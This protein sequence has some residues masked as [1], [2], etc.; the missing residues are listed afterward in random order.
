MQQDT[1]PP[2][3]KH[4]IHLPGRR[5]HR[6]QIDKRNPKRLSCIGLP[7]AWLQKPRQPYT[8]TAAR[9]AAFSP[10]VLFDDHPNIQPCHWPHIGE[11]LPTDSQDFN[12]LIR[13][14]HRGRH[15][16]HPRIERA[17][18]GV[19]LFQNIEFGRETRTLDRV[20]RLIQPRVCAFRPDRHSAAS[21]T[22][23][24]TRC[25]NCASHC[26]FANFRRMRVASDLTKHGAHP[27]TLRCIKTSSLDTP[28]IQNKRFRLGTL[29]KKLSILCPSASFFQQIKGLSL[30][31][32]C[33]KRA[34]RRVCHDFSCLARGVFS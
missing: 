23:G 1:G 25:L 24:Q 3:P 18:I 7:I 22:Y 2:R 19:D 17:G 21:C 11:P 30:V 32:F 8:P 10:S 9:R 4:D 6:L 13:G 28:I 12:F 34:K 16:H 14:R 33:L 20:N 15:L 31:Y 27:K 5:R 29:Q 26:G